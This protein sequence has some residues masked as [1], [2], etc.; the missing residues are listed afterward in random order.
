MML[1]QPS[2]RMATLAPKIVS[3][4]RCIGVVL[5][6]GFVFWHG[7]CGSTALPAGAA[8]NVVFHRSGCDISSA[9]AAALCCNGASPKGCCRLLP[10]VARQFIFDEQTAALLRAYHVI[11]IP[12]GE[13][14]AASE[15]L[16]YCDNGTLPVELTG[17]FARNPTTQR[18]V[19]E[20]LN[21]YICAEPDALRALY[22][23]VL[24]TFRAYEAELAA[25]GIATTRL[26]YFS[27]DGPTRIGDRIGKLDLIARTI[28]ELDNGTRQ[29]ILIGHSFGGLNICDFLVELLGGH[30]PGMPEWKFFSRTRVRSWSDAYKASVLSK[31]AAAVFLNTFVQGNLSNEQRLKK[32]AAEAGLTDPDPVGRYITRVLAAGADDSVSTETFLAD[33]ITHLVLIT[34]RYRTRYY[35]AGYNTPDGSFTPAVQDAL[36][37]VATRVPLVSFCCRVPPVAPFVRVGINLLVYKSKQK[38]DAEHRANDGAVNTYGGIFPHP[39]ARYAVFNN[40]DH[41]TLVM[42]PELSLITSGSTYDQ[43]PFIRTLLAVVAQQLSTLSQNKGGRYS[44]ALSPPC[45]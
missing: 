20:F 30:R 3:G 26:D 39:K 5:L 43:V 11:L 6:V 12:G 45:Q 36:D 4:K 42:Q 7:L 37:A 8:E 10:N 40:M 2:A 33:D 17:F 24:G 38:W 44:F 29:F 34:A 28:E 21:R 31:I 1:M 13:F 32:K 19:E 23:T 25:Q 14:D 27:P 18:D 9:V 35:L 15:L 16:R 22:D 41:G